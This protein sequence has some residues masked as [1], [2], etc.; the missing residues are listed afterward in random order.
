MERGASVSREL[1]LECVVKEKN[2]LL[3]HP[4]LW[5]FVCVKDN[6]DVF[7]EV[8]I[9][10]RQEINQEVDCLSVAMEERPSVFSNVC[11]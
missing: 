4:Y 1:S 7:K 10:S 5:L 11:G 3:P 6:V 9:T 2:L 8:L